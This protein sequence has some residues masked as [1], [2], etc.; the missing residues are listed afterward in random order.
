MLLVE[1]DQPLQRFPVVRTRDPEQMRDVLETTY[2][3]KGFEIADPQNLDAKA[4]Y[5]RLNGLGLG[6]CSYGTSTA[7]E[8]PE[9]DFVRIQFAISGVA[10]TVS[11]RNETEISTSQACVTSANCENRIEFGLNYEQ[12]I[13]R[14]EM[15]TLKRKLAAILGVAPKVPLQFSSAVPFDSYELSNLCSL[16]QFVGDR[17]ASPSGAA[18]RFMMDELEDA[19]VAGFLTSVPH[20]LRHLLDAP[21]ADAAASLV[22][23][24]EEYIEANWARAITVEQLSK[25]TGVGT[26]TLFNAFRRKRGFGPLAFAKMVRLKQAKLLLSAPSPQASVTAVAF[27]CCFS[28]LGHFA[29]DYKNAFGELP[30]TTLEQARRRL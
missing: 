1:A 9:A 6:Y 11:G 18:S 21:A 5:L 20:T 22:S 16:V 23:R 30:S 28:N 7:V 27:K 19:I 4:N 2:G 24:A 12:L 3:A 25:A 14:F 29:R 13:V 15:E 8:F 17:I 10:R 26:R